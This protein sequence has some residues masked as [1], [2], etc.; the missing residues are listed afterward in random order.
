MENARAGSPAA[1]SA[2]SL[3]G[4]LTNLLKQMRRG[5]VTGAGATAT[6]T[7]TTSIN[8]RYDE[9]GGSRAR[10]RGGERRGRR[11]VGW[12][13]PAAGI[14]APCTQCLRHGDPLTLYYACGW[15]GPAADSSPGGA[16]QGGL[17]PAA[18]PEAGSPPPP[19]RLTAAPVVALCVPRLPTPAW[20]HSSP[21]L[22]CDFHPCYHTYDCPQ[23][24]N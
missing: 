5:G 18:S 2:Q 3:S 12:G 7:T 23:S 21:R 4:D 24:S 19:R 13:G 6:T 8:Q 14:E 16:R 1:A 22:D 10:G 9:G 17:E 15:G 11:R 20:D